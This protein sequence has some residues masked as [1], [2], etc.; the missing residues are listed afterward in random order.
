MEL[1]R[2]SPP[3]QEA[4]L[5]AN[6]NIDSAHITQDRKQ[7]LEYCKVAEEELEKIKD[8]VGSTHLDQVIAAYRELGGLLDKLGASDKTVGIHNTV[9]TFRT[10]MAVPS[11]API[12]DQPPSSSQGTNAPDRKSSLVPPGVHSTDQSAPLSPS[13]NT[14]PTY[15][16]GLIPASIFA[17]DFSPQLFKGM[18]PR[19]DEAL[20]DTRQ[21]VYC[22]ALLQASLSPDDSIDEATRTWLRD[23]KANEDEQDR[24][25]T[26][27]TDVFLEFMR[28]GLKDEKATAEIACIAPVLESSNF[29]SL[30][31][32]F[33]TSIR[34]SPL[35]NTHAVEGLNRII[36]CAAP[37]SMEPGDLIK[38]LEH[39]QSWLQSTHTHSLDHVYRLMGTVSRILDAMVD[40]GIKDLDPRNLHH[41]LL[42]LLSDIQK[43]LEKSTDPHLVFKAAYA[44][45][46]LQQV[47]NDEKP[48]R[49]ASRP[50][51]TV[52]TGT[53]RLFSEVEEFNVDIFIDTAEGG[54]EVADN[55]LG[56]AE[57]AY[58]NIGALKGS[59]QDLR[60]ALKTSF[61]RKHAWYTMLRSID[62]LLQNGELTKVKAMA[63]NAPCRRELAFQWGVCQRIANLASDPMWDADS[64]EGA[65]AFLGEIYLNDAVWGQDSK[66]NQIIIDILMQL[67]STSLMSG[68]AKK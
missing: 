64:Q 63:C 41:P 14:I 33:V 52:E 32:A 10:S 55:I 18:L 2:H 59:G 8:A 27:A 15:G 21:L 28:D 65:V 39:F 4:L 60:E 66:V 44:F 37:G 17:K 25:K 54:V 1:F 45:Q 3:V 31:G 19:P 30:L 26:M 58:R 56:R 67:A 48:W 9:D 16:P 38:I 22:L 57:V 11:V 50:T 36:Q 13:G 43:E 68:G 51:E 6:A 12:A 29:R 53:A 47:H 46:A 24:L 34:D 49:T 20:S 7:A 40:G 61:S 23:T 5:L 35:L 62:T 42:L